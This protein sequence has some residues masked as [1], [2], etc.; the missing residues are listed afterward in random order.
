MIEDMIVNMIVVG[1]ELTGIGNVA[2][3]LDGVGA[4]AYGNGNQLDHEFGM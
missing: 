3:Q 4:C 2:T 1:P